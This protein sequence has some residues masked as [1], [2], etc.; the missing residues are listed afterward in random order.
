MTRPEWRA[1]LRF[2]VDAL[3]VIFFFIGPSSPC[4]DN[5]PRIASIVVY[6][7]Y[8]PSL[9]KADRAEPLL[10]LTVWSKYKMQTVEETDCVHEIDPMLFDIGAAFGFRPFEMHQ[11]N[12]RLYIIA[13]KP[14]S[15][16][17]SVARLPQIAVA[18]HGEPAFR[19]AAKDFWKSASHFRT[20][21]VGASEYS[22]Q[23]RCGD[24][25]LAG[26]LTAAE[27]VRAQINLGKEFAWM[28]RIVHGHQW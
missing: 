7:R 18:L 22:V 3:E 17:L 21:W 14:G 9:D 8:G 12:I 28:R 16:L 27:V 25:Q 23:R 5:P 4:W 20:D 1:V 11:E 6:H 2:P 26:K 10:A 24:T 15:L 13:G 19:R